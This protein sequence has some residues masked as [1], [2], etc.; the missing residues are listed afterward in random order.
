MENQ[1]I[2]ELKN[3]TKNFPGVKA[4]RNISFD[5]LPGEVHSL[6]GENGAGKTTLMNILSGLYSADEGEILV[7]GKK[8]EINSPS[9][10]FSIGIG[11]I[12]Q[13]FMLIPT[14]TVLENVIL[15][16][17]SSSEPFL[18]K[19]K[20][21][22]RVNQ[23]SAQY[24]LKM[25]PDVLVSRLSVGERQR[26]E[27]IKIL[28]RGARIIVLDEPTAVL[29]PQ[30]TEE[31]FNIIKFLTKSG[32]SVIFISH[33]LDEVLTISD[34]IT[35][36]RDGSLVKTVNVKDVNKR[37]LASMMVGREVLFNLIKKESVPGDIVLR[38]R[39]ISSRDEDRKSV[40][41]NISFDI[42]E[43]EIFGIAGVSGNGQTELAEVLTGLR[44]IHS[45]S[46]EL[47]GDDF[48]HKSTKEF[49]NMGV[50]HI[51]EDRQSSGLLLPSP[52]WA[53]IVFPNIEKEPFSKNG[54]LNF[55]EIKNFSKDVIKQF[56]I[57]VP[58]ENTL[59]LQLSGGN[60]QKLIIGRELSR[61]P[62]YFIVAVQPTRGLDVGAI[63]YVR[64][65][66]I[67]ERD[68]GSGIL[69]I[70]TELEEILLLSDRIAV[71]Y[72]GEIMGVVESASCSIEE[73][74]LMMAGTKME[75]LH[76]IEELRE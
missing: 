36:L 23:L 62:N 41:K 26:V 75:N 55:D 73:I 43:G 63:E 3:I 65:L 67:N 48:S 2:V 60:Q 21:R 13:H 51:P 6:L 1:P 57:R 64:N 71:M 76:T 20:S 37:M 46:V 59:A 34:R 74:G 40:I 66:L 50:A 28:F 14:F 69:L 19:A 53:N 27:I 32:C 70:S 54:L 16:M 61:K 35:V 8:M 4:N 52:I 58:D 9:D 31:L 45:G 72:E 29:T 49:I 24:N 44:H 30:E 10:A 56:D 25:D 17:E 15:G 12:H 5:L 7:D 33:K 22:D 39:N 42:H 11:M 47:C 18:D 38:V 68:N